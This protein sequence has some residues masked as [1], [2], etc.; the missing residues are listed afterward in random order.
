MKHWNFKNLKKEVKNKRIRDDSAVDYSSIQSLGAG[1]ENEVTALNNLVTKTELINDINENT[2]NT[3]WYSNVF[4]D[5]RE[6]L[7]N[8]RVVLREYVTMSVTQCLC[9][10]SLILWVRHSRSITCWFTHKNFNK[11]ITYTKYILHLPFR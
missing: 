7:L 11:H 4:D 9:R 2:Y 6:W 8:G 3:I 5:H 10:W 1:A